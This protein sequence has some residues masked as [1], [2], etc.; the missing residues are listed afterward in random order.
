M[1]AVDIVG[2]V[3]DG[4]PNALVAQTFDIGALRHVGAGDGVAEIAQHLGNPAHANSPDPD[5]MDRPNLLR[6][7]QLH[8]GPVSFPVSFATRSTRSASRSAASTVPIDL[9]A[10]AIAASRPGALANPEI[11]AASRSGVNSLWCRRIAPPARS[12]AL[13]LAN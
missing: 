11:S 7:F 6:Q 13:A 5:E 10:F 12:N 8:V 1:C 2:L 4:N 3:S 9:A